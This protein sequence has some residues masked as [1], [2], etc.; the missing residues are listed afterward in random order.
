VK[1]G[2]VDPVAVIVTALVAGAGLAVQDETS[3]AVKNAYAQLLDAVRRRLTG[4]PDGE[5]ALALNEAKLRAGLA[6]LARE[7]ARAGAGDDPGLVAVAVAL[8][9][10]LNVG[11]APS[12]R[13]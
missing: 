10:L 11:Q 2:A 9:E 13:P 5:L 3:D 6:P 8:E 12:A 4:H 7:L 1:G